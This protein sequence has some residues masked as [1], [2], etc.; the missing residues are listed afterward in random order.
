MWNGFRDA[1]GVTEQNACPEVTALVE[2]TM[3]LFSSRASAI[4]ALYAFEAQQPS[5]ARSKLDGLR[6]HYDL[7]RA[8]EAYFALHADDYGEKEMLSREAMRLGAEERSEAIAACEKTC[9][10]MWR[11]LDGVLGARTTCN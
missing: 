1:L 3:K 10:A 11:A 5:T 9:R 7:G 2:G 6:E 4:G 8:G